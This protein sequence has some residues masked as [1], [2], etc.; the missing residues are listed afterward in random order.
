MVAATAASDGS[1]LLVLL[2]TF[3][4]HLGR[5]ANTQASILSY[6]PA[7]QIAASLEP[8]AMQILGA[9]NLDDLDNRID[10]VVMED[11]ITSAITQT[12]IESSDD[13]NIT[14][15]VAVS[16]MAPT[17]GPACAPLLAKA[18]ALLRDL[19]DCMDRLV[20]DDDP[21]EDEEDSEFI[22]LE[23][24]K[25]REG[26]NLWFLYDQSVPSSIAEGFLNI[27]RAGVCSQTMMFARLR[28]I[29]LEPW[30]SIALCERLVQWL[31]SALKTVH[32]MG[33]SDA[34]EEAAK[35]AQEVKGAYDALLERA[36]Q[37]GLD[38][39]PPLSER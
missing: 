27:S 7:Q 1:I 35:N 26:G 6:A 13:V 17:F 36:R 8:I 20:P 11:D 12:E 25:Q 28:E 15:S 22:T 3:A 34:L 39:Y 16:A 2:S 9:S 5:T 21:D 19:E 31:K 24:Q 37:S 38:I 32:L 29:Q 18:W 33:N 4:R 10:R 23:Q 30:L 14:E